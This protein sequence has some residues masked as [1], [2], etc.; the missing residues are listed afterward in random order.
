[1]LKLLVTAAARSTHTSTTV[2]KQPARSERGSVTT[3]HV[4]WAV[5]VIAIVGIVVAAVK[6]YVTNA[7]RQHQVA[8]ARR[9]ERAG[10]GLD[11][12]RDPAARAL[13]G[14]VP[15]DAGRAV[16]PRPDGGDR[17]RAG[18]RP[19]RRSRAR[20]RV[21]RRRPQPTPSSPKPAATTSSR[22]TS[23]TANRTAHDGDRDR[24]RIQPERD[25]RL[26]RPRSPRPP[27]CRS[28]GSRIRHEQRRRTMT[29]PARRAR[30][31]GDRGSDRRTCLRAV[32]RPDHL[33]RTHR[34]HPRGARVR[35]R[36]RRPLGLDRARRPD[37]ARR[38]HAQA[39]TASI[40][41]PAHPLPQRRRRRRHLRLQQAARR[42]RLGRRSP[43]P[44]ASTSPTSPCRASRV[45]DAQQ[46]P[47][48]APST[49]GANDEPA[50]APRTDERGS[51][52]VWLALASFVMIFLVGLAVDLGGQV[53]AHERA[54]D[55]AAQ[56]ARAGGEEVEGGARDPG[57]RPRRSTPPPPEQPPSATSTPPASPAPSRSPAATPSP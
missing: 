20:A 56:A 35:C 25:P 39:A 19:R 32:R 5:A 41:Q 24:H 44:A 47:C 50:T 13:R 11:R 51:I 4:L 8:A 1:M 36:R 38:M 42:A 55:L 40:D 45:R 14:D 7:G 34:D 30:I 31:G 46:P 33:R 28:R 15:G 22:H 3:E 26:E 48:P 6:A 10:L 37:S 57:T 2:R 54:H 43:S 16:L 21:R 9:R 27:P 23:T 29:R 52:T 18:G 49:P 17:G 53:H 12:A